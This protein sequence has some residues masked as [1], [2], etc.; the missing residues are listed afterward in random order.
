MKSDGCNVNYKLPKIKFE[1]VPEYL[2]EYLSCTYKYLGKGD[3]LNMILSFIYRYTQWDETKTK[4]FT[5]DWQVL[6]CL[7]PVF[8]NSILITSTSYICIDGTY[9]DCLFG[10]SKTFDYKQRY[11]FLYFLLK[12]KYS[13]DQCGRILD[14][15]AN[16]TGLNEDKLANLLNT[17]YNWKEIANKMEYSEKGKEEYKFNFINDVLL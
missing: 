13:E 7:A 14:Y 11:D 10:P 12:C 8:L 9:I 2:K 15:Y 3:L 1:D 6:T 5:D 17:D 4:L 16:I